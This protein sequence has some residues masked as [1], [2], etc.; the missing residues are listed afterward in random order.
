[1]KTELGLKTL[2]LSLSLCLGSFAKTLK[3]DIVTPSVTDGDFTIQRNGTGGVVLGDYSGV[4]KASTGTVSAGTVDLTSEV[5][6]ILPISNGG[7]GSSSQNFVDLTTDQSIS[8]VKTFTDQYVA[9]STTKGMRPC[10]VMT[11]VQRDAISSPSEGDCVVN[12][13]TNRVNFYLNGSW[14]EVFVSESKR[15]CETKILS[16]N[17]TT[18]GVIS[19]LTFSSMTIGNFY[20][21]EG[22]VSASA[23]SGGSAD[24]LYVEVENG[25][26]FL[27]RPWF[28]FDTAFRTDIRGFTS[29]IFEATATSVTFT[30]Q[31]ITSG[32]IIGGSGGK[33][34]TWAQLCEI[35]SDRYEETTEF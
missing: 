19:D 22:M 9:V 6:G 31:S 12:S 7:T 28:N 17:V 23:P 24:N 11:E 21:V 5:N 13:D 27:S 20:K 16:A 8:G 14:L 1:M 26:Q 30:A 18:D 32:N 25:A 29:G 10:P 34:D 4:L 33:E 35:P 3:V 2:L 15:K